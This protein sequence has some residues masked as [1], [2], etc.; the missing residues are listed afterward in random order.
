MSERY[1]MINGERVAWKDIPLYTAFALYEPGGDYIGS[2]IAHSKG[3]NG[4]KLF[5]EGIVRA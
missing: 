4:D 5:V 3:D 2:F 1:A